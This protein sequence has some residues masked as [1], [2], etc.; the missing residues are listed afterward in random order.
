V[1]GLTDFE[2]FIGRVESL[3]KLNA[4][5]AKAALEPVTEI[6]RETAA[7]GTTPKGEKWAP[8]IGRTVS[9]LSL[10][11]TRR[12]ESSASGTKIELGIGAPWVFHQHGAGGHSQT[13]EALRARKRAA[14]TRAKSGHRIEVSRASPPDHPGAWRRA[15][16]EDGGSD[17]GSRVGRLRK[18]GALMFIALIDAVR[19]GLNEAGFEGQIIVDEGSDAPNAQTNY[20]AGGANRVVFSAADDALGFGPADAGRGDRR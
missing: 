6:A 12:S 19:D 10:A 13:K 14:T 9:N 5:V 3:G 18:G 2:A 20:G 1:S 8:K 15:P 17:Q 4:N 7:A 16:A 11:R